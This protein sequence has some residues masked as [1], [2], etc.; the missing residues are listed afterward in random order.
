VLRRIVKEFGGRLA[1]DCAVLEGGLEG[2]R[3]VV[4]DPVVVL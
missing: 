3:L 2:G 1:L 4:G